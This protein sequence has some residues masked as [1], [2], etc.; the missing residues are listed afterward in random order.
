MVGTCYILE[1]FLISLSQHP[2]CTKY[3]FVYAFS[4]SQREVALNRKEQEI[5]KKN[6]AIQV[7]CPVAENGN[8][9]SISSIDITKTNPEDGTGKDY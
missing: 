9:A 3:I 5:L 8:I 6:V 1:V 4:F 2:L 7:L